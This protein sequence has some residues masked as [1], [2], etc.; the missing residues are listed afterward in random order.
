MNALIFGT[1]SNPLIN[2]ISVS[3]SCPAILPK[4]TMDRIS[5]SDESYI[6]LE[7]DTQEDIT[8]GVFFGENLKRV[9]NTLFPR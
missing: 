8:H 3:Y 2:G 4:E 6:H 5:F 7:E 1:F 9:K